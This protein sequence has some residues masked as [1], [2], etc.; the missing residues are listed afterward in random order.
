MLNVKRI[1]LIYLMIF[2]TL[3]LSAQDQIQKAEIRKQQLLKTSKAI[4]D[5]IVFLDNLIRKL[6]QEKVLNNNQYMIAIMKESTIVKDEYEGKVIDEV[7]AG[8]TVKVFKWRYWDLLVEYHNGK[9][10]WIGQTY[11]IKNDQL[12]EFLYSLESKA[13]EEKGKE[14]ERENLERNADQKRTIEQQKQK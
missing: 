12:N 9:Y 10:G 2:S 5:S 8:D 4:Q 6:K 11:L 3:N 14:L 13:T 1:S 7:K